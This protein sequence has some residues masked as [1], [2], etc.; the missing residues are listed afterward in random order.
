ML[1][2][3]VLTGIVLLFSA[4]AIAAQ[5]ESPKLTPVASTENQQSLIREGVALHDQ[6]KYDAAIAKYEEVLKENPDSVD[7]LYEISSTYAAKK[8]YQ[9]SLEFAY[10]G[11]RYKSNLLGGFY[12]E[13]GANLDDMGDSKKAIELYKAGIKFAPNV[14]LLH[15]N[16]AITYTRIGKL[17]EARKSLKNSLSLNPNH[18]SSHLV[19][20]GLFYKGDYKTP[21]LLA[22]SRFLVLEPESERSADAYRIF[23]EI[24]QGGV[25]QDKDSKQ[26]NIL[27]NM[28][29]KKDEGDFDAIDMTI[30]L[31]KAGDYLEENKGKTA[32]QLAVEQLNTY[33]A[34]LG[35]LNSKG[36]QSK[37]VFKYYVPYFTELKKR[38]YVEPFYYY[39]SRSS[40]N[41]E[42]KKWLD[43][44]SRQVDEFL[45]WS[46]QYQWAKFAN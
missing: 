46:K 12:M 20:G 3:T 22:L 29:S 6:G 1:K 15:F 38:N 31:T 25:S 16:L 17:E 34:I 23:K 7:A 33:L 44:N 43:E 19:L 37:F 10:R 40:D 2:K 5:V 8:D 4:Y 14:A 28:S 35:E 24:L 9:K 13:I 32:S 39:I 27:V 30:G 26:I 11:T 21:A 45:N 41:P 18:A 42:V 36:N